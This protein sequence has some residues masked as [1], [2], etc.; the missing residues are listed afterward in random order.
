[1]TSP[2]WRTGRTKAQRNFR[3]FVDNIGAEVEALPAGTFKASGTK[4]SVLRLRA[5]KPV[6]GAPA[7]RRDGRKA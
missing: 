6:E 2:G 3:A 1:M 5:V 4:V 7:G